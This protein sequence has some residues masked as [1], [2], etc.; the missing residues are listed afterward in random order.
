M[1]DNRAL[2]TLGR[3]GTALADPT[4]RRILLILTE[5]AAYPSDLADR[6]GASR[7]RISN[8]LMCLR[9]CGL[10]SASRHGRQVRYELASPHL[11][12]ALLDLVDL[13]LDIDESHQDL[14][15]RA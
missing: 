5:G 1:S 15:D 6:I 12:H 8:H 9:G 2:E 3:V 11:L 10:V 4:R 7:P 14:D 13:E